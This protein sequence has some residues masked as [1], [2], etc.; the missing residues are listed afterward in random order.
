MDKKI[1]LTEAEKERVSYLNHIPN[2]YKTDSEFEEYCKFL[3]ILGFPKPDRESKVRPL[4]KLSG[5]KFE[6]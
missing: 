6:V 3:K 1:N 5:L 4:H 2:A